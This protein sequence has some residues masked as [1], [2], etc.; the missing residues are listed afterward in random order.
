[1]W[2]WMIPP[3]RRSMPLFPSCQNSR[4]QQQISLLRCDMTP[5]AGQQ[6][7]GTLIGNQ[8][9]YWCSLQE[10]SF[11]FWDGSLPKWV[12]DHWGHQGCEGPLCPHH[13][14]CRGLL[15]STNKL[16]QSLAHHL[17][18]GGWGQLCS[19][20]NRGRE[21]LLNSYQEGRVLGCLTGPLD[22]TVTCQRLSSSRDRGHWRGDK[23]LPCHP[24]CLQYCP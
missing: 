9:F 4:A 17:Y 5:R 8:V 15:S 2:K 21:L 24:C 16:S 20:L 13:Q 14:G 7:P 22:S 6:G 10:T 18:Q 19:H 1:M 12:S 23:G 3:W 11:R